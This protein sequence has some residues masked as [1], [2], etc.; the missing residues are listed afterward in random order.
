MRRWISSISNASRR[1]WF[2][3]SISSADGH[4]SAAR[5]PDFLGGVKLTAP[6][7]VSLCD[8]DDLG[9]SGMN[10]IDLIVTV[11]AV[12]SPATCEETHLVFNWS[13]SLQQC[14]M[15][16]PPYIAQWIGEHPKWNAVKWRCEYPHTN[17]KANAG[18]T[19]PA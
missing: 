1:G 18:K 13:G 8:M 3:A 10:P 19:T 12:L 14:V 17:D 4:K 6:E 11:C 16:A 9:M 15:A 5:H 7:Y 2:S